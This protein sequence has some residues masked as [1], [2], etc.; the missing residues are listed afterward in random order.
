MHESLATHPNIPFS[1]SYDPD[2]INA[3]LLNKGSNLNLTLHSDVNNFNSFYIFSIP[4][5]TSN[6]LE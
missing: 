5:I 4:N 6:L 3:S 1:S 2:N